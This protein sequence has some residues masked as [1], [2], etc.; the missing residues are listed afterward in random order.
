M[1]EHNIKVAKI[2]KEDDAMYIIVI[3]GREIGQP[4]E[5]DKALVV[6]QW[7]DQSIHDLEKLL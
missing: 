3:D 2:G 4:I 7:L 6:V 1:K 5:K